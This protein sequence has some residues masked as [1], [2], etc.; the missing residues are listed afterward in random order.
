[1]YLAEKQR[2]QFSKIYG[3]CVASI[4]FF[5]FLVNIGMTIGLMPVIGIPLPFLV[6]EVLRFGGLLCFCLYL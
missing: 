1:M 6:M 4:F 5:H 3:Y 2:S